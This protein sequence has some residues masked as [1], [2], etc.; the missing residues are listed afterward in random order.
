MLR[1][2]TW[3]PIVAG[4]AMC[5]WSGLALGD[6]L[7]DL[8]N[9]VISSVRRARAATPEQAGALLE[10]ALKKI[11]AAGHEGPDALNQLDPLREQMLRTAF[12]L[13]CS[14]NDVEAAK[15]WAD[16]LRCEQP[17][18]ALWA[19][20]A[21][22][23]SELTGV[24]RA[25]AQSLVE[26]DTT[27]GAAYDQ[28]KA[29]RKRYSAGTL[30]EPILQ[31]ISRL[32]TPHRSGVSGGARR[33]QW[34]LGCAMIDAGNL[35]EG[36]SILLKLGESLQYASSS[37]FARGVREKLLTTALAA[38]EG[39]STSKEAVELCERTAALIEAADEQNATVRQKEEALRARLLAREVALLIRA[40]RAS[41]LNRPLSQLELWFP[42]DDLTCDAKRMAAKATG[43]ESAVW[44][45]QLVL[46][47]EA[48]RAL[49]PMVEAVAR[50]MGDLQVG[51]A[52][53]QAILGS[54]R[55]A[56]TALDATVSQYE[57]TGV[58]IETL[59]SVGE[60]ICENRDLNDEA[61]SLLTRAHALLAGRRGW[62]AFRC[63][64]ALSEAL[65]MR[66]D[67][68]AFEICDLTLK[69]DP[70]L[71]RQLDA[72]LRRSV[73]L[74][75]TDPAASVEEASLGLVLLDSTSSARKRMVG[76]D[77][78][79]LLG[80]HLQLR[81]ALAL[82]QLG[83]PDEAAQLLESLLSDLQGVAPDYA[84]SM[85]KALSRRATAIQALR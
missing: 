17:N 70:M 68:R 47:T 13:A 14:A 81:Q 80:C 75:N 32:L 56:I 6:Q 54:V 61:C 8:R 62:V 77:S 36:A 28:A 57:N 85:Q 44:A 20:A 65:T 38:T 83:R 18:G 74:I 11:D 52:D 50:P 1:C 79:T 42:T 78:L 73:L 31:E 33:C 25:G 24:E 19:R 39:T 41:E 45:S 35:A 30:P 21:L 66:G 46:E 29:L 10:T 51:G 59:V 3:L 84:P 15:K 4:S 71:V 37:L 40:G 69:N 48:R 23:L 16:R 53:R 12:D 64:N 26:E 9:E 76:Q 34:L 27:A 67:P 55:G 7:V 82:R 49:V 72:H 60:R 58:A 5:L 22:Q 2:R 63:W 43:A